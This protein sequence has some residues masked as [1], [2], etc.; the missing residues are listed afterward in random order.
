MEGEAPMPLWSGMSGVD[1]MSRNAE[2]FANQEREKA[3]R[4]AAM[5]AKRAQQAKENQEARSTRGAPLQVLGACWL[6]GST[7]KLDQGLIQFQLPLPLGRVDGVLCAP[8][9]AVS[10]DLPE[11]VT[12][13]LWVETKLP[14]RWAWKPI[15][16]KQAQSAVRMGHAVDEEGAPVTE[17]TWTTATDWWAY[18]WAWHVLEAR[19]KA[20]LSDKPRGLQVPKRPFAFLT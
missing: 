6:C 1:A 16:S 15:P 10:G 3:V 11:V 19:R 7:S 2:I 20:A 14:E 8:C 9:R 4:L 17:I 12:T 5:D 18:T 13:R